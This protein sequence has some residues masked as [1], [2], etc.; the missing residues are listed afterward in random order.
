MGK[1]ILVQRRGRDHYPFRKPGHKRRGAVKYRPLSAE[2]GGTLRGTVVDFLHEPGRGAPLALVR[3]E[4]EMKSLYLPPEGVFT[5]EEVEQ[6]ATAA[7]RVGSVLPLEKIPEGSLLFN[8]EGQPGD[9]GK[10]V[11]GSGTYATIMT[12][13]PKVVRV[14]LPSGTI[15]EFHP[16]CRATI[17]VVA[18]G[19]RPTK[20]FV[21]AG[22]KHHWMRAKGIKYPR[23]RSVA[24]NA[25]SHPFGGGGKQRP[26]RPSTTSRNAPPGRKVGLIAARR[27]GRKKR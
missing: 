18:G 2:A 15:R 16:R 26:G 20:P 25:C 9:G 4:D 12:K 21:K 8:L 19:G 10:F 1:R 5:G 22:K 14:S 11:R 13:T 7:L 27:T 23:T 17:G 6:G 3:W 24:M